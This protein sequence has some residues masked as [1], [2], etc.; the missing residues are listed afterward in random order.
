MGQLFFF[1]AGVGQDYAQ[2]L[3]WWTKSANRGEAFAE[4]MLANMYAR[5]KQTIGTV[6]GAHIFDCTQGCGVEKNMSE[7]F[8]WLALAQRN[9]PY[10]SHKKSYDRVL[11]YY[12]STM[13]LEE[14]AVAESAAQEWKPTP[15]LCKQRRLY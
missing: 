12:R 5:G 8:K 1:G 11:A 6:G 2:A 15:E 3:S 9:S 10:D 7:A 14:V 4:L 13:T